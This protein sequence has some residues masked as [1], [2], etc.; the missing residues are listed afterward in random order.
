M[1]R[2]YVH[3]FPCPPFDPCLCPPSSLPNT[4]APRAHTVC[5]ERGETGRDSNATA[6]TARI[7][8][9]RRRRQWRSLFL[10]FGGELTEFLQLTLTLSAIRLRT[11]AS[12]PSFAASMSCGSGAQ[13]HTDTCSVTLRR[14][15]Q[16][17][18]TP[19]TTEASVQKKTQPPTVTPQGKATR[20]EGKRLARRGSGQDVAQGR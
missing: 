6:T 10:S 4:A 12:F 17:R 5:R 1:S 2:N 11:L 7:L 8:R 15:A 18:Y 20:G 14:G 9:R 19:L 3:G 16:Q 13:T